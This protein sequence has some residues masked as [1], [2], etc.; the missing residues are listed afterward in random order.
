AFYFFSLRGHHLSDIILC[1]GLASWLWIFRLWI[2]TIRIWVGIVWLR[3]WVR[4]SKELQ[5][6]FHHQN[7]FLSP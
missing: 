2:F 5:I 3:F 6:C 1:V 7:S 4:I